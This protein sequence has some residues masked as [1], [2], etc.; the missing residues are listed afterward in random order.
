MKKTQIPPLPAAT[1]R[2]GLT[3]SI[4]VIKTLGVNAVLVLGIDAN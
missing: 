4:M 1:N 3:H 2:I